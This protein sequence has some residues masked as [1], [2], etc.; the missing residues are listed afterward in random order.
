MY[1]KRR[2]PYAVALLPAR[3]PA[4]CHRFALDLQDEWLTTLHR[5]AL[6]DEFIERCL[7]ETTKADPYIARLMHVYRETRTT[8]HTRLRLSLL[9]IDYLLSHW[10][11]GHAA[12]FDD[13]LQMKLV[14]IV[15]SPAGFG[16]AT[17][18]SAFRTVHAR[19]HALWADDC[20]LGSSEN[21]Q[22]SGRLMTDSDLAKCLAGGLSAAHRAYCERF[23]S[24]R[25]NASA[26]QPVIVIVLAD[27]AQVV[28][29]MV[30]VETEIDGDIG[31][32]YRT[33]DEV[34]AQV[35]NSV[36]L[37]RPRSPLWKFPPLDTCSHRGAPFLKPLGSCFEG[38]SLL[39][40][41]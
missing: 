13:D 6:D 20:G 40:L 32:L 17:K 29:D 30:T 39:G 31:V 18:M 14:E 27:R 38:S 7:G 8:E 22:K 36:L 26:P 5:M 2:A 28:G 12:T 19:M 9:R 23:A 35:N 37:C 3:L 15:T 21:H 34:S 10:K 33:L 11:V 41:L 4:N 16:L 25:R 1:V 24:R